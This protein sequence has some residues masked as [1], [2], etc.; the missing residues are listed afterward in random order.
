MSVLVRDIVILALAVP[1][2]LKDGRKSVCVAAWQKDLGL[3]RIYPCYANMGLGRWKVYDL[4]L[5][6]AGPSDNREESWK[7]F[8]A[9]EYMRGNVYPLQTGKIQK[10]ED[11]LAILDPLVVDCVDEIN[12][13]RKSLCVVRPSTI[14]K[15]GFKE[16]SAKKKSAGG[17]MFGREQDWVQTKADYEYQPYLEFQ[18]SE[19]CQK[20]HKQSVIEWGFYE[21]MRKNPGRESHVWENTYIFQDGYEPY[22]LLGNQANQR[23]SFLVINVINLKTG[24]IRAKDS[25]DQLSLL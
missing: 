22:L 7:L 15:A 4:E 23:T 5:E 24:A 19:N 11:K 18:C 12:Q 20:H 14:A 2:E 9:D 8:D 17:D 13:Q 10:L 6:K 25:R 21:W 16:N 1:S 3:I